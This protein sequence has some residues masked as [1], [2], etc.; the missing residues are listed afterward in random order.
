MII[1][2]YTHAW[3]HAE[4]LGRCLP[5]NGLRDRDESAGRSPRQTGYARHLAAAE[6]ANTTIV[7]G[8][9][10]RYLGAEISN[11]KVAAYVRTH[12]DRLI[13]FAGIDPSN[14]RTAMEE[15]NVA[16]RELAMRGVA[17]APA[18]QDYHPSNSQ[19]MLVYAE[20]ARLGL[21]VLFHTGVYMTSATKLEFARPMLLDEVAR[22]LPDLKMIVAQMGYPWVQETI[23]LL[24]KHRNVYTEISGLIQQPWQAYHAL[25]SA[26]QCGVMD[27]LLFGSGFP[28]ACAAQ[29]IEELYHL[30]HLCHGTNL[31]TIPREQ[32]RGIISRDALS[33][34]GI[35]PPR[36]QESSPALATAID[37]EQDER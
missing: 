4:E 32:L 2:C 16:Q 18:A 26:W 12:A 7:L 29:C 14:P 21:P 30:N 25:L 20:A 28:Q 15:M 10:S 8:F 5:T 37:D 6:P 36:E 11:H 9:K 22:E 27:K 24:A 19:A 33:L 13:G 17:V 31:P 3:E 23:A 34:L 1:D 35:I